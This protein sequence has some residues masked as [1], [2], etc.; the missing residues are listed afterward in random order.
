MLSRTFADRRVFGGSNSPSGECFARRSRSALR[1]WRWALHLLGIR[2]VSP[3]FG[4]IHAHGSVSVSRMIWTCLTLSRCERFHQFELSDN[5]AMVVCASCECV[6]VVLTWERARLASTSEVANGLTLP[7]CRACDPAAERR[8]SQAHVMRESV[9]GQRTR[10]MPRF[11]S[12]ISAETEHTRVP[13]LDDIDEFQNQI[14]LVRDHP[15]RQNDS[16]FL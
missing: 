15:F 2:P 4:N 12:G 7:Q 13:F 5:T 8:A 1:C 10:F 16:M 9:N 14:K 6:G 3:D 11:S